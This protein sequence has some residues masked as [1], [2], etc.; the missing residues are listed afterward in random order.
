MAGAADAT[1]RVEFVLPERW[2]NW[3]EDRAMGEW[4]I[5]LRWQLRKETAEEEGEGGSE[6]GFKGKNV[7]TVVAQQ[8]SIFVI[9]APS[10]SCDYGNVCNTE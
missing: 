3:R 10:S 6:A 4:M 9:A 7:W 8:D 1:N 5:L 2:E